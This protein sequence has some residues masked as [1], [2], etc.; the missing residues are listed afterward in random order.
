MPEMEEKVW[1]SMGE[2]IANGSEYD[3]VDDAIGA[4]I[5]RSGNR[6]SDLFV[7]E[8]YKK[9]ADEFG[10]KLGLTR[11]ELVKRDNPTVWRRMNQLQ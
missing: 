11:K 4:L 10:E 3:I 7:V 5:I 1:D 6:I 2:A 9:A 8:T